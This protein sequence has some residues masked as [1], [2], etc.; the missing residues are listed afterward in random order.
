VGRRTNANTLKAYW[1]KKE[2]DLVFW[3]PDLKCNGH[4]LYSVLAGPRSFEDFSG[5]APRV[6]YGKSFVE[7]L[8]ERGYDITTLRFSVC[9]KEPAD[10]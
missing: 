3:H 2:Q 8:R 7:E 5:P 6:V 1:S 10:G 4:L 9:K